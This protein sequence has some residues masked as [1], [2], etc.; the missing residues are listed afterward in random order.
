MAEAQ[1][2][3]NIVN[4]NPYLA[5]NPFLMAAVAKKLFRAMDDPELMA[6]LQM[7]PP[8]PMMGQPQP[9]Q[10]QQGAPQNGPPAGKPKGNGPPRPENP[11][12]T[13][14]NAGPTPANSGLA[15]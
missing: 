13:V 6:A 1:A 12:P 14:P 8:M 10:P 7:A 15:Q 5:S 3:F 9:G 4:G 11:G 2:A